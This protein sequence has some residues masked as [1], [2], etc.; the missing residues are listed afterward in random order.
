MEGGSLVIGSVSKS[1]HGQYQC[2]AENVAGARESPSV[3]LGVH[4]PPYFISKPQAESEALVGGDLVLECGAGGD[5]PPRIS[6][7]RSSHP[8]NS[9][10][11]RWALTSCF[12]LTVFFPSFV[13]WCSSS[14]N[15]RPDLPTIGRKNNKKYFPDLLNG[16]KSPEMQRNSII[17]AN[18]PS[19]PPPSPTRSVWLTWLLIVFSQDDAWRRPGAG[20]HPPQPGGRLPVP[21]GEQDRP[22]HS[23]GPGHSQG[24]TSADCDSGDQGPGESS[25]PSLPPFLTS[26]INLKTVSQS[27]CAASSSLFWRDKYQQRSFSLMF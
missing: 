7:T 10:Q 18:F 15:D 11:L 5:P 13:C 22:R 12:L 21:G 25:S 6:W 4:Q 8:V 1:D 23:W 17:V 19:P 9:H 26:D 3:T 24:E 2:K 20:E 27:F 14:L 16:L